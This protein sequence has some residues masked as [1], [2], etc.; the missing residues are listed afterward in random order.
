V[1]ERNIFARAVD[2]M[3]PGLAIKRERLHQA[4]A[5]LQDVRAEYAAAR[6]NR[7]NDGWYVPSSSANTE[8]SHGLVMLR[9]RARS[10][11]RDN[12][13]AERIVTVWRAHLVGNGI[14]AEPQTGDETLDEKL[15]TAWQAFADDGECDA[16]GLNDLYGLQGLVS[17]AVVTDGECLVRVRTRRVADGYRVPMQLQILE[18]DHL[19]HTRNSFDQSTGRATIMGIQL[20]PLGEREGYWIWRNHPGD[21][22]FAFQQASVFV[23]A[24]QILHIFRRRRPGQMRG[25]SWMHAVINTLRDLD[26]TWDALRLKAKIEACLAIFIKGGE[27]ESTLGNTSTATRS[28]GTSKRLEEIEPGMIEYLDGGEGIE[29]VNPSTIGNHEVVTSQTLHAIAAGAGITPRPAHRRPERRQLL[30]AGR[31]QDRVSPRPVADPVAA[32]HPDAVRAD[33]E[34]LARPRRRGRPLAARRLARRMDAA[35]QRADRPQEGHR[36][37]AGRR[38]ARLPVVESGRAQARRRSATAGRGDPGRRRDAQRTGPPAPDRHARQQRQPNP[39]SD[40]DGQCGCIEP[41]SPAPSR[42]R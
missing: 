32:V 17:D 37:R 24:D 3:M 39:R 25:V 16:D 8:V 33:L 10:L 36:R 21:N 34:R 5:M 4:R 18:A 12:P 14:I 41:R 35:A 28:D 9:D 40:G 22:V 6:R 1:A 13:Y 15:R 23:P 30:V 11:V 29:T 26:D 38:R 2:Y 31:G 20:S 19:D 42:C 7:A 27:P